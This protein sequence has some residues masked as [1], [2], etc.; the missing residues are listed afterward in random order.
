MLSAFRVLLPPRRTTPKRFRRSSY[1][2]VFE[3]QTRI[4]ARAAVRLYFFSVLWFFGAGLIETTILGEN[5][6]FLKKPFSLL[7][8]I[9]SIRVFLRDIP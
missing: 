6:Y 9:L 8:I 7:E 4:D 3:A 2:N 5:W 1:G